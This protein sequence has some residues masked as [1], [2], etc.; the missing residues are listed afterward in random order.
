M[1]TRYRGFTLIEL[2]VVMAIVSALLSIVAPRYMKQADR[3]KEVA[4][5]E[6]LNG[7]RSALDHYYADRGAYPERLGELVEKRYLRVIPLDPVT[8]RRDTWIP[9]TREEDE[10]KK[11]IQD[12]H[13]GAPGNGSD[14]TAFK[15]W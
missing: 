8:D 11:V 10:G 1:N 7:L 3:A 4:L 12:V 5:K 14:G 13:S 9:A 2:L 6:N 15:T